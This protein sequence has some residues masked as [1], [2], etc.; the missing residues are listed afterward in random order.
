MTR[1]IR[2]DESGA[3]AVEFALVLPI[4]MLLIFGIIDGGR[5]LWETNRAEKATQM[6]VRMAVVTAPVATGLSTATYVDVDPDGAGPLPPIAQGDVIP[7]AAL[8][9]VVCT[10]SGCCN[11]ASLCTSP[12]PALGAYNSAAFT[13][14]ADRI[15]LMK[16]DIANTNIAIEYR[17][18]GLGYAGDPNGMEVA[19]L[20]TV[21]LTGVTFTPI[22]TLLFATLTLPDS[23]STLTIEDASGLHS[24]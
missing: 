9:K 3:S 11:P 17:G 2:L 5:L 8:G 20:V 22:T 6:G 13:R 4:L 18:S 15:R 14:I 21:R 19:P 12:Y 23:R 24:N 10:S 16:P 7:R 1:A